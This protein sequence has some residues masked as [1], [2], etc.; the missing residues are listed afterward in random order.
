MQLGNIIAGTLIILA[1]FG[2]GYLLFQEFQ[3]RGDKCLKDLAIE[4]CE[5]RDYFYDL[6]TW[7]LGTEGFRCKLSERSLE[8]EGYIFIEK[9]LNKCGY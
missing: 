5:D 3:F 2:G 7:N 8:T 1:I 6:Q 9:E 4:F